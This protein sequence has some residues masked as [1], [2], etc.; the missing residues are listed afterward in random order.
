MTRSF[1]RRLRDQEHGFTLLEVVLAVFLTGTVVV[2]SVVVMGTAVRTAGSSSGS[3][4]LQQLVQAQIET[5]QQVPYSEIGDY[6]LLPEDDIPKGTTVSFQTSDTGT[7]YQFP[8]P[9][10]TLINNVVQKV[11]V[12]AATKHNSVTMSFYKIIVP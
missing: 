7:N 8:N 9:D 5:I 12:T 2:G 10:G 11:D 6:P 3:L 4:D 1:W